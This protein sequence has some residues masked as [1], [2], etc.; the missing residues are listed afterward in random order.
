MS[1]EIPLSV[2]IAECQRELKIRRDLFPAM[3]EA[4]KMKAQTARHRIDIMAEVIKT[5]VDLRARE[6]HAVE[7]SR[8]VEDAQ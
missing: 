5:L 2:M 3:I 4:G 1:A 7:L 6:Q 8:S